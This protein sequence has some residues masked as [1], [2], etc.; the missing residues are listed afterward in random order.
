MKLKKLLEYKLKGERNVSAR[1]PLIIGD[2]L[3][4]VFTFHKKG[5]IASRVVCLDKNTFDAVWEYDYLF[6]INNIQQSPSNNILVCCMDGKLVELDATNGETLN[7]YELDM[8][9]CGT[10]SLIFDNKLLV[11]GVQKTTTINCFDFNSSEVKWSF[12]SQGHSYKPVVDSG[13]AYICTQHTIRCFDLNTGMV[14][15]EASEESTYMF[16][17]IVYG[18]LVMVGGHG[19]VNIYHNESGKL[20]NQIKTEM[21]E[22]IRSIIADGDCIFFGDEAGEFY[23]FK[24]NRE[25]NGLDEGHVECELLWKFSTKGSIQSFPV[26]SG[27]QVLFVNDDNKMVCLNKIS[28]DQLCTFN[29]K[30]EASTSGIIMEEEIIYTAVGKGFVYKL[31]QAN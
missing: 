27:D 21:A 9:R 28:G 26:I 10:A 6:V 4:I 30:G 11:G 2:H 13:K 14:L 29:T 23:S 3:I 20:L 1:K 16:N 12:D 19:L 22:A 24:I 18:D 15:W 8:Y 7:M 17:P 5:G 31:E 25:K